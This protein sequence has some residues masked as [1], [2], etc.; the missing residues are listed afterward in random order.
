MFHCIPL[1]LRLVSVVIR[2]RLDLR[3]LGRAPARGIYCSGCPVLLR[4]S[5]F[6]LS[7]WSLIVLGRLQTSSEGSSW[8]VGMTM[9]IPSVS[10]VLSAE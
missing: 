9:L 4:G 6:L 8:G 7:S 5:L 3:Q 10:Q 1:V 2:C